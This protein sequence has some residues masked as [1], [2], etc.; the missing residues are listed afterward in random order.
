MV[1]KN[2]F[3]THLV[4]QVIE[5]VL[6]AWDVIATS[7]IQLNLFGQS[8]VQNYIADLSLTQICAIALPQAYAM[9][10]SCSY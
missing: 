10:H 6:V 3:L 4:P 5:Q 7:Y 2:A 1:V 8:F 9:A